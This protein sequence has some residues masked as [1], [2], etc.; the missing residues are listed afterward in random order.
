MKAPAAPSN[1]I[2]PLVRNLA[3]RDAAA[4]HLGIEVLEARPGYARCG[5]AIEARHGNAHGVCHGGVLF[6]LADTAFGYACNAHGQTAVAQAASIDF[7]RPGQIGDR[8]VAIAE[9]RVRAGRSGVYDVTVATESGDTVA[10]FRGR[11][12]VVGAGFQP[13]DAQAD[14]ESR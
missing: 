3:E 5:L 13:R 9:E 8:L 12:R 7:V 6:T 10:L 1:A 11:S 2:H 4:R 14:A